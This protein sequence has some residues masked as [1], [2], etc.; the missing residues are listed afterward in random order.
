MK[1][2]AD[3]ARENETRSTDD[4]M[5]WEYAEQLWNDSWQYEWRE[6]AGNGRACTSEKAPADANARRAY[7]SAVENISGSGGIST[8]DGRVV[9]A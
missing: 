2:I 1:C 3:E 8:R 9:A 5:L 4:G 7:R 6:P